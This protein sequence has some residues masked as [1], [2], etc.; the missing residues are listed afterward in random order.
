MSPAYRVA[1]PYCLA[2]APQVGN[3]EPVW[4][5]AGKVLSGEDKICKAA[6]VPRPLATALVA[7]ASKRNN[8]YGF[9]LR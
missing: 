6:A 2:L 7:T 1:Q 9:E 8:L 4:Y 3:V 5:I